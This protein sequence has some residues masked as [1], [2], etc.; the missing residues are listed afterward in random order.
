MTLPKM[1]KFAATR[2]VGAMMVVVIL[3]NWVRFDIYNPS[4]DDVLHQ[5]RIQR[6]RVL[7]GPQST[8][9][10]DDL[11]Q[12]GE[13]GR[14]EQPP[15]AEPDGLTKVQDCRAVFSNLRQHRRFED[16]YEWKIQRGR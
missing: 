16:T 8:G 13:D 3:R 14:R 1:M 2:G 15:H 4:R 10:T 9:P 11:S 7:R 12:P 6:Q 5:V